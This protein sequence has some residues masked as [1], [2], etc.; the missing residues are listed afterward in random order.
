MN[1][2]RLLTWPA[3]INPLSLQQFEHEFSA[4]VELIIVPG[5][6]ELMEQMQTHSQEVD[7]LVPPEV[8]RNHG[9]TFGFLLKSFLGV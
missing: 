6:A 7:A 2:L 8:N 3:Y 4:P 9:Q 1:R 5:A